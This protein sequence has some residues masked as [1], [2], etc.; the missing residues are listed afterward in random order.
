MEQD[1]IAAIKDV[2]QVFGLGHATEKADAVLASLLGRLRTAAASADPSQFDAMLGIMDR[3]ATEVQEAL[4]T[5]S[6]LMEL[7]TE[8]LRIQAMRMDKA[9]ADITQVGKTDALGAD[10][11]AQTAEFL[12]RANRIRDLA[13]KKVAQIN[14]L[15]ALVMAITPGQGGAQ[16]PSPPVDNSNRG[17]MMKTC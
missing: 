5:M 1:T 7:N 12:I 14:A 17:G 10:P 15:T 3:I 13:A 6:L 16:P 8:L 4:P 2:Q 9:A 11:A